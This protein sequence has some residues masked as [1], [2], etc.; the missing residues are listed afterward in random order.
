ME[1]PNTVKKERVTDAFYGMRGFSLNHKRIVYA[2][3]L[4]QFQ[5]HEIFSSD[6]AVIFSTKKRNRIKIIVFKDKN[7]RH[8]GIFVDW[9][10]SPVKEA[11][12]NIKEYESTKRRNA[13]SNIQR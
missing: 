3:D 11:I 4:S 2:D 12:A 8:D 10:E 1:T 6:T 5:L 13:G 9:F 7:Y